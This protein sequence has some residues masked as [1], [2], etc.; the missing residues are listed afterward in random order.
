[1]ATTDNTNPYGTRQADSSGLTAFRQAADKNRYYEDQTDA[2]V[3]NDPRYAQFMQ[4][5]VY[6]PSNSPYP[7]D[8]ING[9]NFGQ[10]AAS[11]PNSSTSSSS[12]SSSF[13]FANVPNSQ[14]GQWGPQD[15]TLWGMLMGRATQNIIPSASDPIIAS[16]VGAYGAQQQRDARNYINQEAESMGPNANLDT[17]KRMMAE[18]AAQSTGQLQAQLLQNELNARRQEVA[19][20]LGQMGGQLSAEDQMALQREL[21]WGNIDLQQGLGMGQLGLQ[22]TNESNYWDALR[23]GLING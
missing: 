13:N 1:M 14:S 17:E 9:A 23:S 4:T 8:E 12:P 6:T 11:M 19:Q 18:N 2:N 16:Q 10:G 5:G 7:D 3:L 15:N 22:A 21:G 20:A